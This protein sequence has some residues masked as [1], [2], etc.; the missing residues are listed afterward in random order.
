MDIIEVSCSI[1]PADRTLSKSLALYISSAFT[2]LFLSNLLFIPSRAFTILLKSYSLLTIMCCSYVFNLRYTL[3]FQYCRLKDYLEVV[4][5]VIF[6]IYS[7]KFFFHGAVTEITLSAFGE[8]GFFV[9][10]FFTESKPL[11]LSLLTSGCDS[12]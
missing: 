4:Y 5:L 6:Y 1:V 8:E 3:L 10:A 12:Y 2:P 9:E 11:R 7:L